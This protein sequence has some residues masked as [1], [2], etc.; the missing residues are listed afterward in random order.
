MKIDHIRTPLIVLSV[1]EVRFLTLEV[2][3]NI[4]S[5]AQEELYTRE[6]FRHI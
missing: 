4:P 1:L 6:G 5:T 2:R 3:K